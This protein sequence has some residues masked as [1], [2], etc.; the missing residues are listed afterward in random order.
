[1]A[2]AKAMGA[3]VAAKKVRSDQLRYIIRFFYYGGIACLVVPA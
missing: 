2:A 1:M 3:V